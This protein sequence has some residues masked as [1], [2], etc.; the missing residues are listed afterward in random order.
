MNLTKKFK[1]KLEELEKDRAFKS[2]EYSENGLCP[3]CGYQGVQTYLDKALQC[4][5]CGCV[6]YL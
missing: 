5:M 1:A 3:H 4:Q 6:I 2:K